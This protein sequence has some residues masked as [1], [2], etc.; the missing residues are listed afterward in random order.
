MGGG[1]GEARAEPERVCA[2]GPSP[3]PVGGGAEGP[4]RP[5]HPSGGM[6]WCRGA[7]E[8]ERRGPPG[9]G[10][11]LPPHPGPPRVREGARCRLGSP[12][13]PGAE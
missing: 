4:A 3:D 2:G 8:V 1:G 12:R 6:R 9:K 13:G 10:N 11:R 5:Q 7:R